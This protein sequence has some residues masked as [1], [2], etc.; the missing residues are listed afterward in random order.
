MP[1]VDSKGRVVL[2]K[3]VREQIGIAP[4]TEVTVHEEDGKVIVKPE[5][6]PERIVEDLVERIEAAASADRTTTPYEDLDP[7][8]K[9]HVDAVQ[10]GANGD[11]DE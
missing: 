11:G 5:D 9:K 2:P 7:H 10:D 1:T 4:G 3:E 6:D 8:A